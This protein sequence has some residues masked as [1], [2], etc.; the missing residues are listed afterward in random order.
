[1]VAGSDGQPR[2]GYGIA[3]DVTARWE[4]EKALRE[5]EA[6]FRATMGASQVGIFVL[7]EGKFRYVNP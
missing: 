7:Q 1:M 2:R 6:L 5:S 4:A 3:S